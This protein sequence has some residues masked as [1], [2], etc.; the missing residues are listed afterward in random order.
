MPTLATHYRPIAKLQQLVDLKPSPFPMGKGIRAGLSIGLTFTLGIFWG[1]QLE[2]VFVCI[3]ALSFSAGESSSMTYHAMF[4]QTLIATVIGGLGVFAGGLIGLPW[5]MIIAIMTLLSFFAAIFS[6]YGMP[7]S[8]GTMIALVMGSVVIGIPIEGM[9]WRLFLCFQLGTAFYLLLLGCQALFDSQYPER[10][11]L[12]KHLKGLADY[13]RKKSQL[14]SAE[15]TNKAEIQNSLE[16]AQ[17]SYFTL[18]SALLNNKY[19]NSPQRTQETEK[20]SALLQALDSV[21]SHLIAINHD[22]TLLSNTADWLMTI[23]N[24]IAYKQKTAPEPPKFF[25]NKEPVFYSIVRLSGII[26]PSSTTISFLENKQVNT[27]IAIKEKT[28]LMLKHLIVGKDA[29]IEALVFAACMGTAFATKYFITGNHWFWVPLS[30]ALTMKHDLGSVFARAITRCIGTVLGAVI[31][32][33]LLFL[34]PKGIA[35][36]ISIGVLATLL[37]WAKMIS[38][39]TQVTVITAI[40]LVLLDLLNTTPLTINYAGQRIGDTLLA[41]MI[42]LVSSYIFWPRSKHGELSQKFSHVLDA[43]QRYLKLA[44]QS[45]HDDPKELERIS[46]DVFKNKITAYQGLSDLRTLTHRLIVEPAP[47]GPEATSWFPL[48]SGAERLCDKINVYFLHRT[49][50]S[51]MPNTDDVIYLIHKIQTISEENSDQSQHIFSEQ[52]TEQTKLFLFDIDE[53]ISSLSKLLQK[54]PSTKEPVQSI[55]PS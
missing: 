22:A 52:N 11:L 25:L 7:Y 8:V 32:T 16:S 4:R 18:Y 49:I 2:S 1:Y 54:A 50:D 23:A 46:Q 20:Q 53:E 12:S 34:L 48:I 37:P 47:V 44:C 51:K 55:N 35:L 5:F 33:F 10:Q 15:E 21:M 42:I 41:S 24:A 31:A 29:T 26:W 30:V 19:H 27:K 40:L 3:A 39:A 45:D 28:Y 17:D 9:G 6:N 43:T 36:T 38:Y 13:A 14:Q